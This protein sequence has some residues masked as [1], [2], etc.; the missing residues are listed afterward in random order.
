MCR[1]LV[2]DEAEQAAIATMRTMRQAGASL[3]DIRDHLRARGVRISHESVG[4]ILD[5]TAETTAE[6]AP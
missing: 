4:K 1:C 6:G 2:E 3:M 5:R